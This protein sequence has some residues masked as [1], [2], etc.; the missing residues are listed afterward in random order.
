VERPANSKDM[1]VRDGQTA[2]D[3]R[4]AVSAAARGAAARGAGLAQIHI[5]HEPHLPIHGLRHPFGTWVYEQY[6]VKQ[7]QEWLGHS[8]PA[9]T[10]RHYVRL[11]TATRAKAVTAST[12]SRGLPW[13]TPRRRP[14]S[15]PGRRGTTSSSWPAEAEPSVGSQS[16]GPDPLSLTEGDRTINYLL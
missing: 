1:T 2:S 9:T 12:R 14:Q 15:T 13:S 11:T 16:P 6:G 8:V 3:A 10:L 4:Q 5:D 7:A